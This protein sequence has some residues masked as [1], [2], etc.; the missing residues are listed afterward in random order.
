[1]ISAI[2]A[3]PVHADGEVYPGNYSVT[4]VPTYQNPVTGEIED[5]GQNPSLGGMMVQAQV[6]SVGYVEI[7]ENGE[8]YLNTRWNQADAN[9]Y[10]T[11]ETSTT[12]EGDWY[13]RDYEVTNQVE[14]GEYEF[15]GNTFAAT[16]TDYRFQL[17]TLNDVIRCTNYVEAMGRDCVWYCYLADLTEYDGS[18]GTI[19]TPNMTDY[20]NNLSQITGED[21]DSGTDYEEPDVI[22]EE[23]TTDGGGQSAGNAA[24]ATPTST[25]KAKKDSTDKNKKTSDK[26]E[27]KAVP[28]IAERKVA[29][30]KTASA[31]ELLD[32][33]EGISDVK[34]EEADSS[35]EQTASTGTLVLAVIGGI[36]VGAAVAGAIVYSSNRKKKNYTDLFSDVDDTDT[37]ITD[38]KDGKDEKK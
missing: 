22:Y 29:D 38:A 35:P 16:V 33:S 7:T 26:E 5:V 18:W 2:P 32:S 10:A 9:I 3:Q 24:Q 20:T 1:M 11:F 23:E 36:I 21:G 15:M 31:D 17:D 19:E 13:V 12:G 4:V 28:T 14:A 30:A 8:I 37:Q 6:Q 27:K 34:E 25:P